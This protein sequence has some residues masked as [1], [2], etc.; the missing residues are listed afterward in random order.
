MNSHTIKGLRQAFR[1]VG[2]FHTPPELALL[3]RS[4]IP[5][6]PESVYDPTCGAGALL[7]VFPPDTPKYGQDTDAAALADAS[8]LPNF[9]GAHGDTLKNPAFTD[10]RFPAI[11]A[12]P[13]FSIKWEPPAPLFD[14]RF[15]PA[16]TIPTPARADYAFLLH[17]LHML[18]PDGTAAV[19]SFPGVLYRGGREGTLRQW[20]VDDQNVI[21]Q[22]ISIPGGTFE[23][24]AI[25]TAVIVL[26]KNRAPADP[27]VFRDHETGL[28]RA[29]ALAE[30]RENGHNLSVT[31][32][33]QP[34]APEQ[35]EIDPWELEQAARRN[36]A[37]KLR[38]ELRFS[39]MVADLEG[40]PFQPFVTDL[41]GV[42]TE[43]EA[44]Q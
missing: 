22:V 9:H 29:V 3:L 6:N 13:P 2:K 16:P 34:P 10:M 5:G 20:L 15:R 14:D 37:R 8:A 38:H 35:P 12:N 42:L 1:A 4:L 39:R 33:V 32:Y 36:A 25:P 26:R 43:F 28:E 17:I 19:L 31:A 27:V 18:T 24:T 23:D 40:W 30:I 44:H 41:R 7:S 21:D 11:V